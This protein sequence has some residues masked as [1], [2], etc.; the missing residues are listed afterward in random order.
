[1]NPLLPVMDRVIY[2]AAGRAASG[3]TEQVIRTETLSELYRHH[4]E[5]IRVGSRVLVVAGEEPAIQDSPTAD[6]LVRLGGH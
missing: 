2:L 6:A 1:M 4:V 5:V 3:T